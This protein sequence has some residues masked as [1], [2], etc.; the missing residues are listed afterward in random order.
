ML[1]LFEE[2]HYNSVLDE[3]SIGAKRLLAGAMWAIIHSHCTTS[4]LFIRW[5]LDSV[6][7]MEATPQ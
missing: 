4:L 1:E 3:C 7:E 6:F 5:Q 2:E